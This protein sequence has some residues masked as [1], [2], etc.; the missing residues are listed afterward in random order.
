MHDVLDAQFLHDSTKDEAYL[1]RIVLPLEL[2]LIRHPRVVVK[3][4]CVNAI[5]YGAKLMIPGVLRFENGI[6]VGTE[7]VMM[8]TKGEAIALGIAQMPTSVIAT[9]DH[10]VVAIIKRVIMERDTY[11][12]RWGYGPRATEKKKLILAGQLDKKGKPNESTPSSWTKHEGYTPKLVGDDGKGTG[13]STEESPSES[14]KRKRDKE[15]DETSAA[16][17]GEEATQSKKKN[18]D[19]SA[20]DDEENAEEEETPK[21][22]KK[23]SKEVK[24]DDDDEVQTKKSSK[25]RKSSVAEE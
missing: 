8:T 23:K 22:K 16:A 24:T 12:L 17:E 18:K 2:L 6:D 4:S 19:K 15:G 10:G 1:R 21:E 5:T 14:K 7:I 13:A 25:K 20:D 3:D 11:N 9:V